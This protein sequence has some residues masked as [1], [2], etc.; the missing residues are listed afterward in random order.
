MYPM[1]LVTPNGR[2]ASA[3][4]AEGS[5]PGARPTNAPPEVAANSNQPGTILSIQILRFIAALS[6]V[7]FHSH[8]ALKG[9]LAGHQQDGIDH[10]FRVGASGVHIFFVISGFVMAY[11]T[12]QSRLTSGEFLS[13]RL[14]RIYPIY[15]VSAATYVIAH[16]FLRTP[17]HLDATRIIGAALLLPGASSL[18]I[19]P[20]WTLSFEMYFYICF[21]LALFLGLRRGLIILSAYYLISVVAGF[22]LTPHSSIGSVASNSLLLEFVGGAWLGLAFAHGLRVRPRPGA[23]LVVMALALFVSGFWLPFERLP[24]VISW[25]VPSLLLVTGALAFEPRLRTVAGRGVAKLG[26][27]SYLLYLSHIL[28]IDLLIATPISSWD[29]SVAAAVWLSLPIAAICTIG[30]AFGYQVIELPMLKALKNWLLPRR[31]R[32]IYSPPPF[33]LKGGGGPP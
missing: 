7:L 31:K 33:S 14:I 19:G 15:W 28:V 20:G 2:G 16:V 25:G 9:Q 26:D 22:F 13:R 4:A 11:T 23:I 24:S 17:Y 3:K 21:A 29:V 27:S 10:A 1:D 32:Q 12:W 30:A 8:N 18:I 5:A 6:V